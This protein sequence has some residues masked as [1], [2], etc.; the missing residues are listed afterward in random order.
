MNPGSDVRADGQREVIEN[1]NRAARVPG[2]GRKRVLGERRASR[3]GEG[4]AGEDL[5]QGGMDH[6]SSTSD[7]PFPHTIIARILFRSTGYPHHSPIY[8]KSHQT[9]GS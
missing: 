4:R 1:G 2:G 3:G 5:S 6:G 9:T 7:P 8:K